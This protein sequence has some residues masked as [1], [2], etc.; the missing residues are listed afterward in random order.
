MKPIN[1]SGIPFS[2]QVFNYANMISYKE[3]LI[4]A[5]KTF[6]LSDIE[7]SIRL[8]S[9]LN[10]SLSPFIK[11]SRHLLIKAK[12]LLTQLPYATI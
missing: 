4:N 9:I 5:Q 2:G 3:T 12:N 1:K 7:S 11:N 10:L 6:L 8:S